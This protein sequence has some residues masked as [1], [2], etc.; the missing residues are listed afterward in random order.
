MLPTSSAICTF[1][2]TCN[3]H[4]FVLLWFYLCFPSERFQIFFVSHFLTSLWNLSHLVTR[5]LRIL[6]S[7][8]KP[9]FLTLQISIN[10]IFSWKQ[11]HL[12]LSLS[13]HQGAELTGC[14]HKVQQNIFRG[15]F[16]CRW[17]S[18]WIVL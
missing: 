18:K 8:S 11:T 15:M 14:L 17:N 5:Q 6:T 4:I 1:F 9:S 10:R 16:P 2:V 7:I 12:S 13:G 3:S